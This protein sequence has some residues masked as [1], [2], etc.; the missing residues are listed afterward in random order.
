M[1]KNQQTHTSPAPPPSRPNASDPTARYRTSRPPSLMP[2]APNHLTISHSFPLA[3]RF[4]QNK[5]LLP[6]NVHPLIAIPATQPHVCHIRC[7]LIM[8]LKGLSTPI[9]QK[10]PFQFPPAPS[11]YYSDY[12]A[13]TLQ[14][15]RWI[16]GH[17]QCE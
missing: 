10:L 14:F 9:C 15:S 16:S 1:E 11:T 6:C 13:T 12:R 7:G 4:L 8:S 3:N 2:A 5:S 17:H